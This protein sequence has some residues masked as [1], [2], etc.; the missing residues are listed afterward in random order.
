MLY[1]CQNKDGPGKGKKPVLTAY[2]HM[3]RLEPI[4][5]LVANALLW[6]DVLALLRL[7]E[8]HWL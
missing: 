6:L 1:D 5:A 3:F 4:A 8:R 2:R 7:A